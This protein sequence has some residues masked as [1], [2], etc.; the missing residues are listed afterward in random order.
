[1]FEEHLMFIKIIFLS[2]F[3]QM[4]FNDAFVNSWH[5]SESPKA[6]N[7]QSH[8]YG[9]VVTWVV[10]N[11]S[12]FFCFFFFLFL[13]LIT[14]IQW[15]FSIELQIFSIGWFVVNG[16]VCVS[17]SRL[18]LCIEIL[19][20]HLIKWFRKLSYSFT[21]QKPRSSFKGRM[22]TPHSRQRDN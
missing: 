16:V 1:M 8:N 11:T 6:K 5:Y 20:C 9:F 7:T 4:P 10:G 18:F 21:C 15:L 2:L 13:M 22:S 12:P 17:H 3:F 14:L 19:V